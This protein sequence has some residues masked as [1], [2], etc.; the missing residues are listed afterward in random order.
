MSSEMAIQSLSSME[1]WPD[2]CGKIKY[3]HKEMEAKICE[4]AC[5]CIYY[6]WMN[7]ETVR[8]QIKA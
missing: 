8:V 3:Y 1:I 2:D 5:K 4:D 7:V 6:M